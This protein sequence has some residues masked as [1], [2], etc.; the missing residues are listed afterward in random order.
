MDENLIGY[1]LNALDPETEREVKAYLQTHPEGRQ[2]LALLR[3]AL[4]PL[5]ADR[6]NSPPPPDLAVRTLA[7][8]AEQCGQG[9]PRAPA[10]TN[11]SVGGRP[12]WRRADALVAASI[13]F[14]AVG[15][16]L[17]GLVR[18]R[19]DQDVL[20]CQNN[21]REFYQ[22]LK[23]YSDRHQN[24][25]PNVADAQPPRDVAGLVV[26]ILASEGQL[27]QGVTF[28]CPASGELGGLALTLEQVREM[29]DDEFQ[30]AA[31]R[32]ACC[33]GYSLGYR[34][35][36]GVCQGPRYDPAQPSAHLP[37]MSDCPPVD[38]TL[39]NSRNH[40]GR[41]QNV[42]FMDGHVRFCTS[43]TVGVGGDDIFVNWDNRVAA[44]RDATDAVIG[45]S[46]AHPTQPDE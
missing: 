14:L 19:G 42:L 18:L 22:A 16:G 28:R 27:P 15:L 24:N 11:R 32:L 7:R 46:A 43:R 21:L 13:L 6:E 17:T 2:R 23:R 38:L 36:T 34:D 20:A 12:V 35:A 10:A 45:R 41:G 1:L 29:S 31:P 25:F 3:Q 39:G 8:V 33:Y 30:R 26:P 4:V 44:G 5:E 37:L 40:G 9:L